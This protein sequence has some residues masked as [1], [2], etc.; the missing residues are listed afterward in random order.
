MATNIFNIEDGVFGL[1]V[2]DT[3]AVGYLST[4]QAPTGSTAATAVIADYTGSA[5]FNCQIIN[6]RITSTP[7]VTTRTTDATWCGPGVT[8]QSYSES[9]YKLEGEFYQDINVS[10]GL[11]KFLFL[12]DTEEAYFLIGLNSETD[13]PRA[14]GRVRITSGSFGGAAQEDLRDTFS[15]DLTR[16][17]SIEFGDATTSI[18]VGSVFMGDANESVTFEASPEKFARE[19]KAV[20]KA[21]AAAAKG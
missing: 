11:S 12:N 21:A 13:P 5:A 1:I 20:A 9:S 19:E 16:K 4:W 8:T 15:F 2:V 7:N 3:G 18:V 10:T 14:I 6:A 17:P